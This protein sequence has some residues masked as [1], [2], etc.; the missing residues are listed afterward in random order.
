MK[1]SVFGSAGLLG[2]ALV[3]HYRDLGKE[4][5]AYTRA[6]VDLSLAESVE[7]V[8]ARDSSDLLLNAAGMTGLEA[9]LD[10]PEGA[11]KVNV[12]APALMAQNCQRKGSQFVHFSTDYVFSGAEAKVLTESDTPS[13][14]NVYGE[15]KLAGETKV[16]EANSDALVCR[17]SWLFGQGRKGFVDQVVASTLADLSQEYIADK[18][19][20]PNF[21]D[22]LAEMCHQLVMK[23]AS[24]VVHLCSTGGNVSWHE[25]ALEV[26]KQM[27][28][29]QL[30]MTEGKTI[31]PSEMDSIAA[32]RAKRP[33][34]TCLI[35]ER[36]YDE[37]GVQPRDWKKGLRTFL[38]TLK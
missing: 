32:F 36:L 9:C 26:L 6:D 12:L 19:S 7:E 16:L 20:V 24:G 28:E 25:Y 21:T 11:H 2:E 1:V 33:R 34:H 27:Q 23:R 22:D 10:D 35:S 4:V 13:P 17:V 15:T 37:F 5:V 31:T 18:W 30:S 38:K 3:R 29:L 8:L 14:I